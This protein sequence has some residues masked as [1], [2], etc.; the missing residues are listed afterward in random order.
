[1]CI[2]YVLFP[3][4]IFQQSLSDFDG[5]HPS[6]SLCFPGST[7]LDGVRENEQTTDFG[8]VHAGWSCSRQSGSRPFVSNREQRRANRL[9]TMS[10]EITGQ[11]Q[12]WIGGNRWSVAGDQLG[13]LNDRQRDVT[14]PNIG[15]TRPS[16]ASKIAQTRVRCATVPPGTDTDFHPQ[17]DPN[18]LANNADTPVV[19]DAS[20]ETI[21]KDEHRQSDMEVN[22]ESEADI[23]EMDSS[24]DELNNRARDA[25]REISE[26][27]VRTNDNY[28]SMMSDSDNSTLSI[29]E[30]Q[31]LVQRLSEYPFIN[32]NVFSPSLNN[33]ESGSDLSWDEY[34]DV[35]SFANPGLMYSGC[36]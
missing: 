1:M 2:N 27:S 6:A 30:D 26:P 35:P 9:S 32:T 16:K 24:V 18:E 21:G 34:A 22:F 4:L 31:T 29:N 3:V 36:R 25:S 12:S 11:R 13:F 5:T 7:S 19:T 15:A 28:S 33:R 10:D 8:P 20:S 17:E 14:G 23:F